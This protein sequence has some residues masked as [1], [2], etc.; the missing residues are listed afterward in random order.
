MDYDK[1]AK[2]PST[3]I[4]YVN[5]LYIYEE[6]SV[7]EN[8]KEKWAC[9]KC[10][11]EF[12]SNSDLANHVTECPVKFACSKCEKSYSY[13]SGLIRH[14]NQ[15]HSDEEQLKLICELCGYCP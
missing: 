1:G 4:A 12:P 11:E 6:K 2:V 13:L 7:Q 8:N 3:S 9:Q 15:C 14:R 10:K 5:S